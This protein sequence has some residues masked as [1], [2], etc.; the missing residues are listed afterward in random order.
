MDGVKQL[1]SVEVVRNVVRMHPRNDGEGLR[2]SAVWQLEPS[3][4]W[5]AMAEAVARHLR[6]AGWDA[7][8]GG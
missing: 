1:S 6:D 5:S 8:L 7:S 2:W 4:S 3:E